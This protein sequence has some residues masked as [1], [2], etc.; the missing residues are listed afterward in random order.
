MAASRPSCASETTS[1]TPGRA[2]RAS[3]QEAGFSTPIP[4]AAHPL[5][6]GSADVRDEVSHLT[7]QLLRLSRKTGRRIQHMTRRRASFHSCLV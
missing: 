7:G 4:D 2:W 5:G 1:F 3:Q 6:S